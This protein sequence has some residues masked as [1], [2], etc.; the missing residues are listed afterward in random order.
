MHDMSKK[1]N[2]AGVWVSF[3]MKRGNL[4]GGKNGCEIQRK[5]KTFNF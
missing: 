5:Q 1:W 3:Q 4:Q 2:A